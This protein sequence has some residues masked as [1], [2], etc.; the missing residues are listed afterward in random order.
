MLIYMH[1]DMLTVIDMSII[2]YLKF[3]LWLC[4]EGNP[5]KRMLYP[6]YIKNAICMGIIASYLPCI[7]TNISVGGF[8]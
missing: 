5:Y 4:A 8:I 7:E 1:H 2:S 3:G 6:S